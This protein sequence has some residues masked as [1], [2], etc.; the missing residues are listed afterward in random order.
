MGQATGELRVGKSEL[1]NLVRNDVDDSRLIKDCAEPVKLI[2]VL[3]K[4][5][6]KQ[7]A[8]ID[9]GIHGEVS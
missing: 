9:A 5:F 6:E 8:E 2:S 3:G 4:D 7:L 1:A